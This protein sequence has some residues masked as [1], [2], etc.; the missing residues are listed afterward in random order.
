MAL[1][2]AVMMLY[3]ARMVAQVYGSMVV[4]VDVCVGV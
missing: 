3:I 4:G 2:F 1:W